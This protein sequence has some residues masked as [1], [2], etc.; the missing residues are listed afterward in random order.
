VPGFEPG[1][2]GTKNR[3]LTAWRHPNWSARIAKHHGGRKA[4]ALLKH[5]STGDVR[6]RFWNVPINEPR[7]KKTDGR[8]L[9]EGNQSQSRRCLLE[10]RDAGVAGAK[11]RHLI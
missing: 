7:S 11:G 5:G 1:N 10:N 8:F 4:G 6:T 3:C 9:A 2:G